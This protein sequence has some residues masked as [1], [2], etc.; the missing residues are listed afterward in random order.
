M[1]VS[2]VQGAGGSAR[3]P[4]PTP[5]PSGIFPEKIEEALNSA[6]SAFTVPFAVPAMTFL[7]VLGA[8][9]GRTRG[10]QVKQGWVV[11]SNLYCALVAR[12]GMGKSP[13]TNAI[14]KPIHEREHAAFKEYQKALAMHDLKMREWQSAFTKAQRASQDLPDK[15][16]LP[17]W[18]QIYV[19]DS[20]TQAVG[21]ILQNNPRGVLWYRDELSGLLS[22]LGRYDSKGGDAGD[23][24]RLLSAYDCGP[25]KITRIT[26]EV[27]HI[28]QAFVAIFG[29]VQPGLLPALFKQRDAISGFLPRFLFIRCEQTE[30]PLWSEDSFGGEQAACIYSYLNQALDLDFASEESPHIIQLSSSALA[31]AVSWYNN[32]VLAYWYQPALEQFEALAPKM[33]GVFFKLIL[34]MHILDCWSQGQSELQVV[35][36]VTVER[37]A[38]LMEWI[39]EQQRQVWVLLSSESQFEEVSILERRVAKAVIELSKRQ[40]TSILPTS[41]IVSHL[42][43]NLSEQFHVTSDA[44]GKSYKSLGIEV[45]RSSKA[46]GVK[47]SP[48]VLEH[49][50]HY[51]PPKSDV[52]GVIPVTEVVDSSK[53]KDGTVVTPSV[54][55]Y[56]EVSQRVTQ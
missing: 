55:S 53:N 54:T 42:N 31:Y 43:K 44:V 41:S 3:L 6:A 32:Q 2:S 45:G 49:L 24:A 50:K 18:S 15:P 21:T 5:F 30:P 10:L 14:L 4:S 40:T 8:S 48:E 35:E 28:A 38:N 20:T 56:P 46:R 27:L 39:Q 22:D 16:T 17:H 29:T 26:K 34:L 23:K 25:W 37:T 11:H 9:I 51:L 36:P 12:S 52:T 19:E 13:C 47:L 33:R 7:A 1:S